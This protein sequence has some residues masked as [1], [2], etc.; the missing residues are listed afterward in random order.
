MET[1]ISAMVIGFVV[2]T[3]IYV[4]MFMHRKP[5]TE[6]EISDY[7]KT[8][9]KINASLKT[10]HGLELKYEAKAQLLEERR[11][12]KASVLIFAGMFIVLA[13]VLSIF[14]KAPSFTNI[15]IMCV[16]AI[17]LICY[18]IIKMSESKKLAIALLS[19][20]FIF[21]TLA[22][23]AFDKLMAMSPSVYFY[24][25]LLIVIVSIGGVALNT[26]CTELKAKK[27]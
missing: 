7:Q 22:K 20:I 6:K 11:Q 9:D 25:C 4:E 12:T 24:L 14:I 2:L 18:G 10:S 23:F 8:L 13:L 16:S 5:L 21:G 17:M 1:T 27:L 19:F 15:G 3:I 26:S